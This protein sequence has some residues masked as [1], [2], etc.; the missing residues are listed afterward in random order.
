[1]TDR[2]VPPPMTT[3]FGPLDSWRLEKI[4]SLRLSDS[5]GMTT[6]IMVR[7]RRRVAQAMTTNPRRM[8]RMPI[9]ARM[10]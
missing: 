4:R 5:P 2:P 3:T 6:P 9:L 1:M 8:T 7:I 10:V